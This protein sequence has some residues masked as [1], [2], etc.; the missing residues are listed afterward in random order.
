MNRLVVAAVWIALQCCLLIGW[1]IV[2][3]VRMLP[4]KGSSVVVRTLP[5]DP[6]DLLR[7][8]YIQLQYPF[9]R[10]PSSIQGSSNSTIW[11]VLGLQKK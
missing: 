11:V 3:S 7:G 10:A 1:T 2:E 5:V 9:S 8:Q 4:D 6:R